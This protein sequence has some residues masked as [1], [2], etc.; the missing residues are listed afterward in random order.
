MKKITLF[1]NIFLIVTVMVTAQE[2][3]K[4]LIPDIKYNLNDM[5]MISDT[6]LWAVSNNGIIYHTTDGFATVQETVINEDYDLLKVF[7]LDS[8]NG[9]IGTKT[10]KVLITTDAG[11]NWEEVSLDSL[12]PANFKFTYFTGLYFV[13]NQ[14][15]FV[16]AGKVKYNYLFKTTDGGKTWAI[17]DSLADG[18]RQKWADIKFF[19]ETKGVVAGDKKGTVRYTTDGGETWTVGDSAVNSPFSDGKIC[20]LDENNV[21]Y[22]GQGLEYFSAPL[23][24][25][26]STD[27]GKT[28]TDKSSALTEVYDRPRSLFFK[29]ANN[30]IAVGDNGFSRMFIMKTTD[31]GE[32][33][34]TVEGAYALG[35]RSL[36]GN[37]DLLYALGTS[38]H[39]LKSSDFGDTW[40]LINLNS[41]SS[42]AGLQF[43]DKKGFAVNVQGDFLI[44]TTN[45]TTWEV[46]SNTGPEKVGAMYF[47]DALKGFV[48]KENRKIVK[49]DDGG[50]T[51]KTVLEALPFSTRNKVGGISFGD[52]NTGYAWFS[53]DDY[54]KYKIYKTTDQGETWT[55]AAA[56]NG[57]G[58]LSGGIKFFDANTGFIA[59]PKIKPDGVY[60]NWIQY[61]TDGGVTWITA[62]FDS[63]ETYKAQSFKDATIID[64]STA[65]IVSKNNIFKSTD[66]GNSWK[67][68]NFNFTVTDSSFYKVAFNGKNGIITT[69]PGEV[70]ITNDGGETWSVVQDYYDLYSPS[71]VAI[72]DYGNMYFGTNNGLLFSY[73]DPTDVDDDKNIINNYQLNQ[74]Y[75]NPFNPTTTIN[76]VIPKADVVKISVFNVLGEKVYEVINKYQQAGEYKLKFDAKHL[77]SGVYI[78]KMEAGN[79]KVSKKMLLLK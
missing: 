70:L 9:W 46:I 27:G 75:P 21:V 13:N 51:W 66:K 18:S 25:F 26:K 22:V 61:T 39:I 58:Y 17:K 24:I 19:D 8:N 48:V 59:G 56:I 23:T 55:E 33:W 4:T 12:M 54:K 65:I 53:I 5:A 14:L 77:S 15:G 52:E 49:T 10:G 3:D 40:E 16:L 30:G 63:T 50:E 71:V 47:I 67:L 29:D 74:N 68:A 43:I 31:A 37:Q 28:W 38:G 78:Y 62:A 41:P 57:P 42:F 6:E 35:L 7:F 69:Y 44:S 34:T 2:W 64:D 72:S 1:F 45:G 60:Q 79:Y 73:V 11:A 76:F 36:V 20:W 32:T